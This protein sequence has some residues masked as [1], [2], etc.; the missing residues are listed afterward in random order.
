MVKRNK[1]PYYVVKRGNSFF[2]P[3]PA[4]KALGFQARPL[5]RDGLEAR[6]RGWDAYHEILS[7]KA[8]GLTPEQPRY[9]RGSVGAGFE[10]YRRTPAW[11]EKAPATRA[12]W[13]YVWDKIEPV[14]GDVRPSTITPNDIGKLR[15]IIRDKI[16]PHAAHRVIKIWRAL[17][18]A[19]VIFGYCQIGMDP[20]LLL[21][22]RA[23]KGRTEIWRE[24]EAVRLAKGAWRMGY[25]GLAAVIA[26]TW[27]TMFQPGDVRTLTPAQRI[28]DTVGQYFDQTR[29]KTGKQVIGTLT[30]RTIQVLDAY[31]AALPVVLHD[32]AP[33]FRNRSGVPY[34]KDTLGDDFRKVRNAVFPGDKRRLMDMRRSGSVEADSGGVS[35]EDLSAKM[36]NSIAQSARL[37][38]TYLPNR[39]TPARQ[40]DEA[41][42]RGR[43]ALRNN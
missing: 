6:K 30:L 27:D 32:N 21:R 31:I 25:H 14:L 39:V 11:A 43:R 3:T 35:A 10:E 38:K 12:E 42:K 9:P 23:P 16:S 22:N 19:M 36:G 26:V 40:A 33:I 1:P 7:A 17:W 13:E 37:Q 24:G 15:D 18:K 34:S 4:L 28:T 41:R 29:G 2:Q 5:G 20:S 8:K